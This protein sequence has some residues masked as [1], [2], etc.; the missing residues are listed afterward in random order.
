MGED[1]FI[2]NVEFEPLVNSKYLTPIRMKFEARLKKDDKIRKVVWDVATEHDSVAT[3][4]FNKDHNTLLFVKQF[5]ASIFFGAVRRQ[6]E[7]LGKTLKEIDFTKYPVDMGYSLEL[8]AGL[9]DKPGVSVLKHAQEEIFEECGYEVP[10]EEIKFLKR[11]TT[12]IGFSG[13]Q[14]HLFYAIVTDDMIV[15]KGGGNEE[16]G[17]IIETVSLTIDEVKEL[18]KQDELC[19]PPGFLYVV[20][21]FLDNIHNQFM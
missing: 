8:C 20:Q 15:N 11:F 3:L 17:E 18:M 12:G 16:E 10:L 9:I 6:K 7:N 14:Q 4:L 21:Y 5:R 19:S 1:T 13:S 2:R